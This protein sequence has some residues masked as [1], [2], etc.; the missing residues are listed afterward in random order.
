MFSRTYTKAVCAY[1][2]IVLTFLFCL[3][4][5]QA[6]VE[7]QSL[8]LYG[9]NLHKATVSSDGSVVLV[10]CQGPRGLFYSTDFGQ[11]WKDVRD[12][13]Y[14]AGEGKAVVSVGTNL[15]AMTN[16]NS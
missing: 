1:I 12:A 15:Y 2:T 9:A 8:K 14:L 6:E 11:T 7:R 16:A 10:A 3:A 5:A 13:T 4:S